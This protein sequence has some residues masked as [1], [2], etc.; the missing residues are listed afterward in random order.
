MGRSESQMYMSSDGRFSM[1]I[2][3][4]LLNSIH[5]LCDESAPLETGGIIIGSYN[6]DGS[7]ASVTRIEG[8]PPDSKGERNRFYRGSRGLQHLLESLWQQGE[9]YLGEWHFHPAG[10]PKPSPHDIRQMKAIQEE[11]EARC[12]EPILIVAGE[13][14]TIATYV[15]PIG[16]A[17]LQLLP[18]HSNPR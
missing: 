12:P 15:F 3:H 10:Q 4:G 9:H 17:I 7:T 16:E 6:E 5:R 14:G 8:P 2:D 1:V 11:R 18:D 13:D